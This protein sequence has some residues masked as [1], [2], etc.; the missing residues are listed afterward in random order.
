MA[1]LTTTAGS[2][3]KPGALVA[4]R[5]RFEAGGIGAAA[6]REEEDRA[7]AE[8]VSLQESLGLDLLV[9]GEMDRVDAATFLAGR[10]EGVEV[11]GPVRVFG[12]HFV[13]RPRIVGEVRRLAPLTV[14]RFRFARDR[15]ARPVKAV[16]AGP[17]T[18]VASAFDEHYGSRE[19]C[20]R[21][22]ATAIA[23][24]VRDLV[25][26]GCREIQ[27][28]ETA[29]GARRDEIGLAREAIET[30]REA[31]AGR[32]RLWL[33]VAWADLRDLTA[34]LFRFPAAG[35]HLE[36]ANSRYDLL[37][38]VGRTLPED[39]LLAAGVVD[40]LTSRVE[41][42]E[43]VRARIERLANRVPP[44]R[45]FLAPDSGLG[46]RTARAAREK[47]AVLVEAAAAA[48]AALPG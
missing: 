22:V 11:S 7:T 38:E 45:L 2:F 34:E 24:E 44:E 20:L 18:L 25:E 13:R 16:L 10:L 29:L 33:H 26:A 42:K 9:D 40:V 23:E 17:Y 27:I 8:C 3:P 5:E 30:V 43:E 46:L 36:M 19:R 28:D 6:L 48:R 4:A 32:A 14:E 39:R 21:D 12:H 15:T 31:A 35:F 47:V 41:R 1:L 37:D